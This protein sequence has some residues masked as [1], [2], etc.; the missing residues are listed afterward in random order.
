[1]SKNE[2]LR[3]YRA[4]RTRI[5]YYPSQEA[6]EVIERLRQRYPDH[7]VQD[8]IDALIRAGSTAFRKQI[9]G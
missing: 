6:K 9:A 2:G 7:S 8:V 1:M 5:D 4:A 3:R